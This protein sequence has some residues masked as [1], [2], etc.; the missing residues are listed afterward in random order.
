MRVTTILMSAAVGAGLIVGDS[1]HDARLR[2]RLYAQ[3]LA[4]HLL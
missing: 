4:L 2:C 1:A 3:Y